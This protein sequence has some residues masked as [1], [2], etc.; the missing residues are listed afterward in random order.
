M[1]SVRAEGKKG[2]DLRLCI[3][4]GAFWPDHRDRDAALA[5]VGHHV[6]GS[7]EPA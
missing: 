2:V 5:G 4:A 1:V 7:S 3:P 6:G